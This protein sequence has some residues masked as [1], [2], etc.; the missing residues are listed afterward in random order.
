MK[1]LLIIGFAIIA[2]ASGKGQQEQRSPITKNFT[3]CI[4]NKPMQC[5]ITF[6]SAAVIDNVLVLVHDPKGQT[7]FLENKNRF[8]GEYRK[9]L[10]L[11]GLSPGD[12]TV[13]VY[14]DHEKMR[15]RVRLE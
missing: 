15:S 4:G 5:T 11:Q 1:H 12:Y 9:E 8:K 14:N 6:S 2:A 3:V 13:Q 10:D 7:V